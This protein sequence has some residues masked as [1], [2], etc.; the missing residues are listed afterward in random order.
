[1]E[2][3]NLDFGTMNK[4]EAVFEPGTVYDTIVIGYGPAGMNAAIY[5]KKGNEC[6]NNRLQTRAVGIG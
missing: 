3:F 1:M 6:R 4:K 5:L 2:G